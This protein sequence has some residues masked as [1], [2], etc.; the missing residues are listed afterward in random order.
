MLRKPLAQDLCICDRCLCENVTQ[1]SAG[2]RGH[3]VM[4]LTL[5][6]ILEGYNDIYATVEHP[7]LCP[8]CCADVRGPHNDY[9][10]DDSVEH[11]LLWCSLAIP[12][13]DAA[14][15][16]C[17]TTPADLVISVQHVP[18]AVSAFQRVLPGT[19]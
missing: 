9:D 8:L 10:A 12:A 18:C 13:G 19:G 14:C 5:S 11:M 2:V 3:A 17:S 4:F 6:H 15:H 1:P 7:R 16:L